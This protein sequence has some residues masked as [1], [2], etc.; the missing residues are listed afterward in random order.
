MN[1]QAIYNDRQLPEYSGL[2]PAQF[3]EARNDKSVVRWNDVPM[4]DVLNHLMKVE[5]GGVW[6]KL[7]AAT[8]N[9]AYPVELRR[10]IRKFLTTVSSNIPTLNIRDGEAYEQLPTLIGAGIVTQSDA[11][12]FLDLSRTYHSPAE[13]E[14]G[15]DITEA[16]VAIADLLPKRALVQAELATVEARAG[17]LRMALTELDAGRDVNIEG[18]E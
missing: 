8:E 5:K 13:I 4:P 16:D 7:D 9:E 14:Y 11:D 15:A 1:Y 3:A 2:T 10:K 17:V 12:M 18:G 6:E